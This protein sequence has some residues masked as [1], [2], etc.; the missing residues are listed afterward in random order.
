VSVRLGDVD[1]LYRYRGRT[2]SS[3][4]AETSLEPLRRRVDLPDAVTEVFEEVEDA[5][6]RNV[7]WMGIRN[8][9]GEVLDRALSLA[10]ALNSLS[11]AGDSSVDYRTLSRRVVGDSKVLER[12]IRA[13]V[14]LFRR[15][16]PNPI[17]D[18]LADEDFLAFLGIERL[19]Q[20]LL[21]GGPLA[22]DGRTLPTVPFF[23]LPPEQHH[24]LTFGQTDYLLTIENY[25]SFVRHCRELNGDRRG[26]VIY[27]GGFPAK[28]I[29]LAIV[30]IAS[31]LNVPSFHWGDLDP[32]GMRI[33]VH[34]ESALRQA[35]IALKSHLMDVRTLF[36][37]GRE[38]DAPTRPL[39]VGRAAGSE[40]SE[41][42]DTL[43]TARPYLQLEQEELDP[44]LPNIAGFSTAS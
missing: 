31:R 15:L 25:T 1:V 37:R 29:L 22:L 38:E 2:P 16:Y 35:G 21:L 19:P 27:T 39:I 12:Q 23:G 34:I 8:G 3:L 5:W 6:S 18:N 13:V 11:L 17:Q 32:G 36:E 20:P 43:A 24:R 44:V 28:A 33:F 41:L 9:E 4:V 7:S 40:V 26:L 30:G 10:K 14:A 42:W